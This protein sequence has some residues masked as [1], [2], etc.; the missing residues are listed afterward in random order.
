MPAKAARGARTATEERRDCIK[1]GF[2]DVRARL[3]A[4]RPVGAIVGATPP[5]AKPGIPAFA[6]SDSE[7]SYQ[8][9]RVG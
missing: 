3:D 9:L 5:R 2:L 8:A 6:Q 1:P 4:C 7:L